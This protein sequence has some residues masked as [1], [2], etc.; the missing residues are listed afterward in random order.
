MSRRF[1]T[2][3]PIEAPSLL[4]PTFFTQL[5]DG[6][7]RRNLNPFQIRDSES[8]RLLF[9]RLCSTCVTLW[10]LNEDIHNMNYLVVHTR[11]HA[12]E[13]VVARTRTHVLARTHARTNSFT[14]LLPLRL[15]QIRIMNYVI[16][17]DCC[18]R[19]LWRCW[20]MLTRDFW[21]WWIVLTRDFWKWWIAWTLA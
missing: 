12:R 8:D 21:K 15:A 3:T 5:T 17:E 7:S 16:D 14:Q 20:I 4:P 6:L 11:A 1:F 19:D 18:T 2:I 9:M 13:H 10:D